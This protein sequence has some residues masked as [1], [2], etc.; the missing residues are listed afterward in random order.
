MKKIT[1]ILLGIILL[2]GCT[3]RDNNTY[4]VYV[5]TKR[6]KDLINETLGKRYNPCE[7]FFEDYE[8]EYDN[9]DTCIINLNKIETELTTLNNLVKVN[10][11]TDIRDN[12]STQYKKTSNVVNDLKNFYNG[13]YSITTNYNITTLTDNDLEEIKKEPNRITNNLANK[14]NIKWYQDEESQTYKIDTIANREI[15]FDTF[16]KKIKKACTDFKTCREKM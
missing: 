10:S 5:Q 13:L 11:D 2:T 15:G 6:V 1:I 7:K 4:E 14:L 9:Y 12:W 8:N 16:A 3:A